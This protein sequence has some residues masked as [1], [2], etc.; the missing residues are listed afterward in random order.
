MNSNL[1]LG[2]M[3]Y[4]SDQQGIIRRYQR[5]KEGWDIHLNNS[6]QFIL[7]SSKTKN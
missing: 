7:E 3:D 5:E 2:K 1:M 4:F 6:K